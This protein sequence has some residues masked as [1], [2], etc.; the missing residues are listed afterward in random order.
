MLVLTIPVEMGQHVLIHSIILTAV[1]PLDLLV[2]HVKVSEN[3]SFNIIG[4][5]L[6]LNFGAKF[7]R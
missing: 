2:T 6:L 7:Q 5:E 3:S 1:V 4:D